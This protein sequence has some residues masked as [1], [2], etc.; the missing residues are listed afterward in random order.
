MHCFAGWMVWWLY[1]AV[2]GL[3]VGGF[4]GLVAAD[5]QDGRKNGG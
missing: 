5:F 2:E 4:G 1:G 3:R